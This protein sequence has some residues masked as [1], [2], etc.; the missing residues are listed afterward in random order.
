MTLPRGHRLAVAV[1]DFAQAVTDYL[2]DTTVEGVNALGNPGCLERGVMTDAEEIRSGNENEYHYMTIAARVMRL[3]N[4][5]GA[6]YD[7]VDATI[8]FNALGD[9]LRLKEA[10]GYEGWDI[11]YPEEDL[12]RE[13]I[14]DACRVFYGSAERHHYL[15]V[16]ARAL[17]LWYRRRNTVQAADAFATACGG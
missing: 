1:R 6:A 9:R 8:F 16:A 14:D 12:R 13:L 11:A 7:M 10:K 17:F 15:D 5:H 3:W 2:L 4:V